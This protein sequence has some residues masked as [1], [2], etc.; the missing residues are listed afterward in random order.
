MNRFLL[1]VALVLL[2]G[3]VTNDYVGAEY[4]PTD[5]VL[6]YYDQASVL[7]GMKVIGRDTAEA[8]DALSTQAIVQQMVVKAQQVGADAI[9]IEGVDTKV[10]GTTTTTSGR[11][12][13]KT[14]YYATADG[15][16]HTRHRPSGRWS[17]NSYSTVVQDKVVTA[18]FLKRGG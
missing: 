12:D 4:A 8:T 18:K 10:V 7:G 14:E 16:L 6:V 2:P 17:S 13:T 1:L 9:L 11:D 3:C 5:H 15:G